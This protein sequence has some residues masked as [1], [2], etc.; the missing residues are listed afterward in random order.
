ME[1][2]DNFFENMSRQSTYLF[3]VRSLNSEPVRT[4]LPKNTSMI[5]NILNSCVPCNFKF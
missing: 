4:M 3:R 5:I 1:V 2:V